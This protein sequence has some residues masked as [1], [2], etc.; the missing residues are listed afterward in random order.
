MN[1]VTK[2]M[3]DPNGQYKEYP[4]KEA[5]EMMSDEW[6]DEGEHC[7][8][9]LID[10]R[11]ILKSLLNEGGK[12]AARI[13]E[14]VDKAVTRM[15]EKVNDTLLEIAQQESIIEWAEEAGKPPRYVKFE[16]ALNEIKSKLQETPNV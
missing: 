15:N 8:Q 6:I 4:L 10:L 16:K 11:D 5:L 3:F 1:N 14:K 13:N 2:Q 12:E 7:A 9:D